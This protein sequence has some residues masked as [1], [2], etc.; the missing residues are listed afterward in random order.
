MKYIA[1]LFIPMFVFGFGSGTIK[2]IDQLDNNTETDILLNP[3]NKVTVTGLTEGELLYYNNGVSSLVN[4]TEGQ[5]LSITGGVLDWI[6]GDFSPLTTKGDLYTYDTDDARLPV[7]TDGQLLSANSA[8]ATGLEWIDAP[9]TSPTT[10]I[11]DLIYNNTGTAAGDT[12]LAIGTE[13]Q[14]LTVSSGVPSWQ[15]APV[16]TTLTTKGDIQTYDTANARLPVGNDG[17]FLVADSAETR[18]L[19]WSNQLQGVLNPI[20]DF[21]SYTPTFTNMGTPTGVNFI[22]RQIGDSVQIIG[23]WVADGTAG[24]NSQISLPNGYTIKSS[25]TSP[26]TL[27]VVARDANGGAATSNGGIILGTGDNAFINYSTIAVWNN[28][29][30]DPF[31]L[32][33]NLNSGDN[34]RFTAIIPVNELSSGLDAVVENRKWC[35][36]IASANDAEAIS[37]NTEDIPWKTIEKDNCGFWDNSGN[38]GNNTNDAFTPDRDM[39]I[40]VLG[41]VTLNSSVS[42]SLDVYA[43]GV[44]TNDRCGRS[45]SANGLLKCFI[46]VTS[47]VRYTFRTN[48]GFTLSSNFHKIHILEVPSDSTVITA[49]ISGNP[50]YGT[51]TVIKKGKAL[52]DNG[53]GG[54]CSVNGACTKTYGFGDLAATMSASRTATGIY[55][56][57]ITGLS[58][59]G[60]I[61]CHANNINDAGGNFTFVEN[62]TQA[63]S[64]SATIEIRTANSSVVL[65][66]KIFTVTCEAE[67]NP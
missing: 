30:V 36:V 26:Q 24:S 22:W 64:G 48:N 57:T 7:G 54:A 50:D 11:G 65:T 4:G 53:A 59:D 12:R 52:F 61:D 37:A 66:D 41:N 20:T 62:H 32:G 3:D 56:L 45:E 51:A 1:L 28:S 60:Y 5:I 25:I 14:L 49:N 43:D 19:K 35:E 33:G 34:L 55:D 46:K 13:S 29:S 16:S 39:V 44:V 38:T 10:T 47:G 31:A 6:D 63:V 9:S 21:Q 27:G 42:A 8:Q 18:G 67:V 17:E 40:A 15:D 58:D 23:S 2:Q